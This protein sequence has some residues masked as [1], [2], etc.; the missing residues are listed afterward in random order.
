[1]AM[2]LHVRAEPAAPSASQSAGATTTEVP[3]VIVTARRRAE[4]LSRT[5]VV[6]TAVTGQELEK[7]AVRTITAL[8][9]I[10]PDV[11]ISTGFTLDT[12][13][14]RGV[15]ASG[16]NSGEEQSV[17]LFIDGVYLGNGHWLNAG[18][19]DVDTAQ[20]LKGP[21]GVYFGKNTIAGAVDLTT[22]SPGPIF[23][24]Y[25]KG[26]Y[27]F[28]ARE[29]YVDAVVSGPLGDTFGARLAIHA[30]KMDGWGRAFGVREPGIRDVVGRLTLAWR[31]T[32]RLDATLKVQLDDY[33][34]TGPVATAELLDCPGGKPS[35]L[36]DG[37]NAAGNAPC[38]RGFNFSA[39]PVTRLGR[40]YS[41]DPT[42]LGSLII[43]YRDPHGELTSITGV[44][45]YKLTSLGEFSFTDLDAIDG[46]NGS[47]N[48]SLS[49]EIRYATKF[50]GPLNGLIGGY[51][52]YGDYS[53][54]SCLVGPV[55]ID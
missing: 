44:S 38:V 23:E 18:Y 39:L 3:E 27:E 37:F 1:M 11:Y 7:E 4:A 24:G 30:T 8:S 17:A 28:N 46:V 6:A 35:L 2:P 20:I 15:G 21:Q 52:Q 14:I 32:S 33:H 50:T 53:V 26:G 41:A 45:H 40:S 42:Q 36:G 29:R 47:K 54:G 25:V 9:Q 12:M 51:Y 48:L 22:N 34:D 19:I 49:Q 5:P 16:S 31:P 43:H 13:F 10:V 55:L